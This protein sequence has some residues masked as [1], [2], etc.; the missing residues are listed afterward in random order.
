MKLNFGTNAFPVYNQRTDLELSTQGSAWTSS[1][2]P[3]SIP[4]RWIGAGWVDNLK[5]I[6]SR[7]PT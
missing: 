1:T 5:P 7:I 2:S 4:G 6:S 3:S